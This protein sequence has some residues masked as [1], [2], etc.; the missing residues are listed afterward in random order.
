MKNKMQKIPWNVYTRAFSFVLLIFSIPMDL[1]D[2]LFPYPIQKP[3]CIDNDTT[4]WWIRLGD[5]IGSGFDRS[6]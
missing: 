5:G 2:L 6:V 3:G 1:Y 4:Q